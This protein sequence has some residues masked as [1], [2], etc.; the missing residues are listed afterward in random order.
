MKEKNNTLVIG[1]T[2]GVGTGKTTV[3][4]IVAEQIGA[5][6]ILTDDLAKDLMRKGQES[7][8]NVCKAFGKEILDKDGEI[9]RKKLAQI[10]FN[11]EH[12][13]EILNE[14][15]H[16]AVVKKVNELVAQYSAENK[17]N[18]TRKNI[19]SMVVI[20]SALLLES[21]IGK[22]CNK[23]WYVFTD[24]NIRKLRLMKDRGYSEER[25]KNMIEKQNH[26]VYINDIQKDKYD[27][28]IVNNGDVNMLRDNIK[29]SI[30][31][32]GD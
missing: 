30:D 9:D 25:V 22:I 32:I 11:N 10:V 5:K 12:K 7:Y 19:D 8:N 28:V 17:K 16:P 1:I 23:V 13:L 24:I 27:K 29:E 4:K 2:G 26:P 21:G 14:C 18:K 6:L 3:A 15:T 31:N 20:E